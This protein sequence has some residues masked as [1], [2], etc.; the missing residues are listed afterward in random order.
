MTVAE[1]IKS[2]DGYNPNADIMCWAT[3]KETEEPMDDVANVVTLTNVIEWVHGPNK[4]QH[5]SA[6]EKAE[7]TEVFLH[8]V[9]DLR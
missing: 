7:A 4:D 9:V 8:G 3:D 2:L 1:L 5:M 6:E